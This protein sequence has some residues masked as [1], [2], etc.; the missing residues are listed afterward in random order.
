MSIKEFLKNKLQDN[1]QKYG[2]WLK[3]KDNMIHCNLCGQMPLIGLVG[4][5][6]CPWCGAMMHKNLKPNPQ[7][8]IWE[9]S[10]SG[11]F[12]KCSGC[13]ETASPETPFC[14]HCGARTNYWNTFDD[15]Q[16]ENQ[17]EKLNQI[18]Y[19][20]VCGEEID[21]LNSGYYTC[22]DN[23]LQAKYFEDIN[24]RDNI[25]CSE[26]CACKALMINFVY[27]DQDEVKSEN[28]DDF[29]EE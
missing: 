25:F 29:L 28:D 15:N 12:K 4:T 21:I 24:G 18:E 3:D 8:T 2:E 16:N 19:C 17:K 11:Y 26:E 9:T 22:Q 23:F 20:A 6:Y 13:Q 7:K 27:A 10:E 14:P 1:S 5:P